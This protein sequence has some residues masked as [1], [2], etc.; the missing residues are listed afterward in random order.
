MPD[1]PL[2]RLVV[3][4]VSNSNTNQTSRDL[5]Y[6]DKRAEYAMRGIPE[7]WLIDP[8]QQVVFILRLNGAEYGEE[9]FESKQLIVSPAFPGLKLTAEQI[10]N[11]G[12]LE[13]AS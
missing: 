9:R 3:E 6:T 5:N 4:V 11:A 2:P 13:N 1:M 8:D 7:Y 10:L 12:R